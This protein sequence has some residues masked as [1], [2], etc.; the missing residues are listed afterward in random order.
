MIFNAASAIIGPPDA[1]SPCEVEAMFKVNV[2][3]ILRLA[4]LFLPSMRKKR[5]GHFILIG[6]TA[7]IESCGFFGIYAATKFALEAI[8]S[9]WATTLYKWGIKT[10]IIEP[11]AMNTNLPNTASIGSYYSEDDPYKDFNRHAL[12]FLKNCLKEGIDPDEVANLILEL[13]KHPSPALRYQT[14]SYSRD[15][16]HRHLCDPES[17]TWLE[18]HRKFLEDFYKPLS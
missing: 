18:E 15:L 2:F 9:S 4:Q 6:S 8:A 7:G 10:T 1:L 16:A 14:C 5:S 17:K 12:I 13:L 3:S 11:G